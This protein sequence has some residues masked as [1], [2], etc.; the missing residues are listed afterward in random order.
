MQ[1]PRPHR[2]GLEAIATEERRLRPPRRP[3]CRS[4]G[5]G[6]SSA[7]RQH[8]LPRF[9][10]AVLPDDMAPPAR[11]RA[12]RC[13]TC[14]PGSARSRARSSGRSWTRRGA[15]F[16]DERS[17]Q[18]R[19]VAVRWR[20]LR[21]LRIAGGELR[22]RRAAGPAGLRAAPDDREGEGRRSSPSLVTSRVPGCSISSVGPGR[23]AIE[24]L[25]RGA[26]TARPRRQRHR[27][28]PDATSRSS[29]WAG[30]RRGRTLGCGCATCETYR[31]R[32]ISCSATRPIHSPTALQPIS[33]RS[34]DAPSPREE[35]V[36]VE[37]SPEQPLGALAP[38]SSPSDATGTR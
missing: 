38:R 15:R 9:R 24:A 37:S 18:A 12:G 27:G 25:S 13:S 28:P 35:G 29:T 17:E 11:G 3:T 23:L 16:G 6:R 2:P 21:S 7:T 32:S 33:I 14:A 34:Y 22:G 4:E 8:G 1:S 10:A 26:E 36:V 5:R 19:R 30:P 20:S 31:S